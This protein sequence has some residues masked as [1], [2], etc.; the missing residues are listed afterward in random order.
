MK[1]TITITGLDCPV[2]AG[3]LQEILEKVDGVKE[4]VV[5][6]VDQKVF[7][8]CDDYS[9]RNMAVQ[10]GTCLG[11]TM[12]TTMS[13]GLANV[14]YLSVSDFN[15]E[16]VSNVYYRQEIYDGNVKLFLDFLKSIAI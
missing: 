8:E 14:Q 10:S 5:S 4:V 11:L 6:H 1:K 15:E 13:S 2:C 9:C 16:I 7:L 12:G 3:E